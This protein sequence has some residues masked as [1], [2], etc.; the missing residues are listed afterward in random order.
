MSMP[1][2]AYQGHYRLD[3]C[4]MRA[5]VQSITSCSGFGKGPRLL[6]NGDRSSSTHATYHA[7]MQMRGTIKAVF[8]DRDAWTLL[9][10]AM[11]EGKLQQ[12]DVL[13]AH[14][15][16]PEFRQVRTRLL[17]CNFMIQYAH[18]LQLE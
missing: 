10:P 9:R 14:E 15:L 13:P 6:E 7:C 3:G 16:R 1:Q 2:K 4:S 11:E 12:L 17:C 5:A 18:V 8:P